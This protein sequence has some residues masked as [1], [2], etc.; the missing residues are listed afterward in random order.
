MPTAAAATTTRIRHNS[1][2]GLG[3]RVRSSA[4]R[5]GVHNDTDD[6]HHILKIHIRRAG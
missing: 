3:L 6:G 1:S 4:A 2:I 5:S